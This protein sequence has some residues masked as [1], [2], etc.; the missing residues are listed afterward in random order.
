MTVCLSFLTL[1]KVDIQYAPRLTFEIVPTQLTLFILYLSFK[2]NSV[3]VL[4]IS[5]WH[6][7]EYIGFASSKSCESERSCDKVRNLLIITLL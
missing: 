4:S 7:L 1:S 5:F 2:I 3:E 6:D